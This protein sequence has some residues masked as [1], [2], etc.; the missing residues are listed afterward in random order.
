MGCKQQNFGEAIVNSVISDRK[1]LVHTMYYI[2]YLL[3]FKTEEFGVI[4]PNIH[5]IFIIQS[6]SVQKCCFFAQIDILCSITRL[7]SLSDK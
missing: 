4:I 6:S 2:L 5:F 7:G 3:L 1:N